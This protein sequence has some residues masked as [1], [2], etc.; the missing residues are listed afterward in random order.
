MA[1]VKTKLLVVHE[2]A[3]LV[4]VAAND[5]AQRVVEH[6][7]HGVVGGHA[8]AAAVVH[9]SNGVPLRP[10]GQEINPLALCKQLCYVVMPRYAWCGCR[11]SQF[12]PKAYSHS[13]SCAPL[14]S[15]WTVS[16]TLI[17]LAPSLI[18]PTCRMYLHP[19]QTRQHGEASTTMT[20]N[21][22]TGRVWNQADRDSNL[23][24]SL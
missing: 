6:V 11:L 15:L 17:A 2:G 5:L 16:P 10:H 3:L 1:E 22:T 24:A 13:V 8:A 20:Q 14:T 12:D 21:D 18:L 7:G 23:R 9:L 19:T 4:G